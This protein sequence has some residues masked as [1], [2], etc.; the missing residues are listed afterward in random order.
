MIGELSSALP[1]KAYTWVRRAMGNFW[2][3][4][5]AWVSLI[6]SV[7]DMA[8]LSTLLR[9]VPELVFPVVSGGESRMV[10]RSG[11]QSSP[12]RS[13]ISPASRSSP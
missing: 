2:G 1:T 12:V 4:Q 9:R 8:I 11:R 13:L 5:E 10:G 3:F 6:A 7:F